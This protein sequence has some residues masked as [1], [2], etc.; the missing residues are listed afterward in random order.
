VAAV[1]SATGALRAIAPGQAQV[2]AM[3]GEQRD[4]ARIVV[5]R[6]GQDLSLRS[7]PEPASLTVTQQGTLR[8]GDT[9]TLEAVARDKQGKLLRS[10]G[11]TWSSSEPQVA[12]VD[13]RRGRVTAHGPGTAII[14]ARSGGESAITPVE[15]LPAAVA[16]VGVDGARPLKVGDTLTLLAQPRDQRGAGLS[17]RD[18]VWASSDTGVAVVDS[19]SGMVVARAPGSAEITATSEEKSGRARLTVLPQPRTGRTEPPVENVAQ[20]TTGPT[21]DD[22]AAEHRRVIE[23]MLAGVERC[24]GALRQKDVARVEELYNAASRSDRENL[25]KLS[26]ILQTSEWAA[27][28]GERE[29]GAQRVEPGTAA[30]EFSFHLT[31]KDAFGGRLNSRP[32]FRAEFA[33]NGTKLTMSSC[34]II[35][36]PKL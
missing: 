18:V 19:A 20:R 8:V 17:Q 6:P 10:S 11:I 22:I 14:I 33:R 2:V 34:H 28:V 25:K 7:A 16:T 35:G 21:A 36:S 13:V 9:I 30:M 4:S 23:Q 15:V 29:D 1:D 26:R 27:V 3:T 24:Y 31:W 32:V 12:D 5:R